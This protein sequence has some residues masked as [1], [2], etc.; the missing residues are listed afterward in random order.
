M[1]KLPAGANIR[2]RGLMLIIIMFHS[3]N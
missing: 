1:I 2:R 3:F